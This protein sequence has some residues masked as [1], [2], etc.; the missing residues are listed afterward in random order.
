MR[1]DTSDVP[2]E[3]QVIIRGLTFEKDWKPRPW[4]ETDP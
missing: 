1:R 4:T 3:H 2:E